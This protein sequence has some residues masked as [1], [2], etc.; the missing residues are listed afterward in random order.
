L[1]ILYIFETIKMSKWVFISAFFSA[2][3]V[4]IIKE[5]D[6]SYNNLLLLFVTLSEFGLIYSYIMLLKNKNANKYSKYDL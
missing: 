1:Y 2:L 5:Y 3:S 6:H 4:I